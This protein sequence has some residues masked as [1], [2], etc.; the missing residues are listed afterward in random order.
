MMDHT[1]VGITRL[2][3][4]IMQLT[5]EA[6][7]TPAPPLKKKTKTARTSSKQKDT[8]PWGKVEDYPLYD[9][10]LLVL[11]GSDQIAF[12]WH[13][14]AQKR[15]KPWYPFG[16]ARQYDSLANDKPT[17]T[18]ADYFKAFLEEIR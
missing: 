8:Q 12:L 1:R 13:D 10:F 15:F 14:T 4:D 2:V 17:A 6:V 3:Q 9:E 11:G 7:T 16:N 5:N 18:T